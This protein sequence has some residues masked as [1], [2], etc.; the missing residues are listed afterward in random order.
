MA[1]TNQV[2]VVA[3]ELQEA[4][5]E[6]KTAI[7]AVDT[8][9]AAWTTD[10]VDGQLPTAA[11]VKAQLSSFEAIQKPGLSMSDAISAIRAV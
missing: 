9:V 1:T 5:G 3:I 2:R 8:V 11:A 7:D 4:V 6:L 10:N